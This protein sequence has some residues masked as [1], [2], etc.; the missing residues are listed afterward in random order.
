MTYVE[1]VKLSSH[2]SEAGEQGLRDGVGSAELVRVERRREIGRIQL[3]GLA[4]RRVKDLFVTA[5]KGSRL[6]IL[7]ERLED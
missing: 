1:A 5:A 6:H 4:A 2:A 7:D 3:Q